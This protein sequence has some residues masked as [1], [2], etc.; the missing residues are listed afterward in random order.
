MH[1]RRAQRRRPAKCRSVRFPQGGQCR[2]IRTGAGRRQTASARKGI[3]PKRTAGPQPR[4][5]APPHAAFRT[6][7]ARAGSFCFGRLSHELR[8]EIYER[9]ASGIYR[10]GAHPFRTAFSQGLRRPQRSRRLPP[11]SATDADRE[12]SRQKARQNAV[13]TD[14]RGPRQVIGAPARSAGRR[15]LRSPP[16]NR[17]APRG[18]AGP[19]SKPYR[20][21][22]TAARSATEGPRPPS[23][24]FSRIRA[25][26]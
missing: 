21:F 7:A 3:I 25:I 6:E 8:T 20:L 9:P 14:R 10:K 26:R 11:P 15:T 4:Q 1:S 5:N 22:R 23:S 18:G 16:R 13:A 12:R 2:T 19:P 24:R 17:G